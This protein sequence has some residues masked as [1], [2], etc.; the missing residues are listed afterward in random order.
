LYNEI[1]G[2]DYLYG[3]LTHDLPYWFSYYEAMNAGWYNVG[4]KAVMLQAMITIPAKL[5]PETGST[6]EVIFS[7][8]GWGF[9]KCLRIGF[10]HEADG[11]DLLRVPGG[12]SLDL[13]CTEANAAR[14]V[15]SF[16]QDVISY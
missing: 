1:G 12:K 15:A 5:Y 10:D 13:L 3:N 16:F 8:R 4:D 14:A 11:F 7:L 6:G 2:I 9:Q